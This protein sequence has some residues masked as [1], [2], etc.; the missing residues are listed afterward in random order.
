MAGGIYRGEKQKGRDQ[1]LAPLRDSGV[2]QPDLRVVAKPVDPY[3]QT[4][5]DTDTNNVF[6]G[7]AALTGASVKVAQVGR[8][9]AFKEGMRGW[10]PS[11]RDTDNM[12]V[13]DLLDDG[14]R[15][16]PTSLLSKVF[17]S[18][19]QRGYDTIDGEYQAKTAYNKEVHEYASANKMATNEQLKA[20]LA[21]IRQK[22]VG[23]MV[24]EEQLDAWLPTAAAIEER[25]M[26]THLVEGVKMQ[27]AESTVKA[28]TVMHDRVWSPV[29]EMLNKVGIRDADHLATADGQALFAEHAEVLGIDIA[30]VQRQTLNDLQVAYG[31]NFTKAEISEMFSNEMAS[32]AERTL[33]PAFLD[34]RK[35]KGSD[36]ETLSNRNDTKGGKIGDFLDAKE[37][38]VSTKNQTM[39]NIARQE[40]ERKEKLAISDASVDLVVRASNLNKSKNYTGDLLALEDD[41]KALTTKGNPKYLQGLTLEQYQGLSNAIQA[42]K[43]RDRHADVTLTSTKNEF[44]TKFYNGSLTPEWVFSQQTNTTEGDYDNFSSIASHATK[45]RSESNDEHNRAW[46][47]LTQ[48]NNKA[49]SQLPKQIDP[50]DPS[51]AGKVDPDGGIKA[52]AAQGMLLRMMSDYSDKHRSPKGMPMAVPQAE[53]D[54]MLIKVYEKYPVFVEPDHATYTAT[55][56]QLI[57]TIIRVGFIGLIVA[58]FPGLNM[59]W[60]DASITAIAADM[61]LSAIKAKKK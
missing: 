51:G 31:S 25:A 28:R 38:A 27:H 35:L 30:R 32:M 61:I 12:P 57:E 49:W 41:L 45:A 60:F 11:N 42:K 44:W 34:F 59:S 37:Y 4:F 22:H 1:A 54:D 47:T 50:V 39:Q 40:R 52:A 46:A 53:L 21:E 3:V 13:G 8:Q 16:K 26:T 5:K 24:S 33:T 10:T 9:E 55:V 7:L 58:Y 14:A 29:L 6:N 18:D 20:G 2:G 43:T 36:G 17:T 48:V 19:Y 15:D 23:S 56:K